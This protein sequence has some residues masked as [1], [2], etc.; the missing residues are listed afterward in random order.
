MGKADDAIFKLYSRGYATGRDA[1]LHNFSRHACLDNARR[2]T[3]EYRAAIAELEANPELTVDEVVHR[4]NARQNIKWGAALKK[5]LEQKKRV[6]FKAEYLRKVSY[7]PFVPTNYYADYTL[8][9]SKHWMDRMFPPLSSENRVICVPGIGS[10]KP[11]SAL[12]T[13]TM[14]ECG[15]NNGCQCFPRWEYPISGRRLDNISDTALAA[16]RAHYRDDGITKDAI[17]DY[18]YGVLHSSVYREKF[19]NDVTKMLP[20]I[21]FAPDFSAFSDA[22]AA[23]ARLHLNYETCEAYPLSVDAP[24][25]NFQ[26]SSKSMRFSDKVSK[27]T[28]II[29]EETRVSGIPSEAHRYVVN[30]RTPLEWLIDRYKVTRDKESGIINDANEWFAEPDELITVIKRLV[31]VSVASTEIIEGLPSELTEA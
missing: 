22:G 1:Y 2:M 27:E 5:R 15:L 18:V 29:N 3:K 25:G 20:R 12:I 7:R 24:T 6:D 23:L 14:P 31:Y 16:F 9:Q 10:K 17:F 30:G 11:F 21:P 19:A 8:A 26:L 13:D 28:L 4:H